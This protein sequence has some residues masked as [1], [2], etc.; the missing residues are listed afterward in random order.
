VDAVREILHR[1]EL[2]HFAERLNRGFP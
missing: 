2:E 1:H